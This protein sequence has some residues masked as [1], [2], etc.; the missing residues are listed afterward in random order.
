[1]F[2]L[3]SNSALK[4]REHFDALFLVKIYKK[5]KIFLET[6]CILKHLDLEVL[7]HYRHIT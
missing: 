2:L 4:N 6:L 3:F 5:Y 7:L 1:M